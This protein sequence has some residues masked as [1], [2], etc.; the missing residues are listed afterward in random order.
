MLHLKSG[1]WL[2]VLLRM[3]GFNKG[4]LAN[5]SSSH[6]MHEPKGRAELHCLVYAELVSS[7]M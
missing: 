6:H 5:P 3:T 1:K 2:L 7:H 4:F